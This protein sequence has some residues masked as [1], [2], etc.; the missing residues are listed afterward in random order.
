MAKNDSREWK[1]WIG[2]LFTPSYDVTIDD[3]LGREEEIQSSIKS[4]VKLVSALDP[5]TVKDVFE[6]VRTTCIVAEEM[7]NKK[8]DLKGKPDKTEEHGTIVQQTDEKPL[9]VDQPGIWNTEEISTLRKVFKS[10][11]Q[12]NRKLKVFNKELEKRNEELE[13][14]LAAVKLHLN[15]KVQDLNEAT[16]ANKRLKILSDQLQE[17]L[18]YITARMTAMEQ[19]FKEINEEKSKMV[20]ENQEY[21]IAAD[22]ERLDRERI[23]HQ[24]K[25][26]EQQTLC[27]KITIEQTIK[28]ECQSEISKLHQRINELSD[29]LD[30]ERRLHYTTRK[31]LD[32]LRQHFATLPLSNI[33][34]PNA[35][36]GDQISKFSYT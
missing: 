12:H 36:R 4:K 22:K 10:V 30:N 21:K 26:L 29:E 35:V 24:L 17:D 13:N 28:M 6:R 18:G 3:M 11:K 8:S 14:E 34:P 5:D 1:D 20:K 7:K 25:T 19:I 27:E 23:E 2:E 16:K 32:H 31:G 33:I 9:D 15:K